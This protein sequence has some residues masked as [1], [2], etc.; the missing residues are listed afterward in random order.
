MC[1]TAQSTPTATVAPTLPVPGCA[2]DCPSTSIS[3]AL[4]ADLADNLRQQWARATAT[5]SRAANL[6]G[7]TDGGGL[8][9]RDT[10][11][12]IPHII[13]HRSIDRLGHSNPRAGRGSEC[14]FR[15]N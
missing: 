7:S 1:P 12:E 3:T 11:P 13:A 14:D 9:R 5:S 2:G 8:H 6:P 10:P 4:T 15:E